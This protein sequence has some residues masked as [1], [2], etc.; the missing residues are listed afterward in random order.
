[1]GLGGSLPMAHDGFS[2]PNASAASFAAQARI[3]SQDLQIL[4]DGF[5]GNGVSSGCAVS[6]RAAGAN[7]SVDIAAG[8]I[9]REGSTVAV[10]SGN[11]AI[12]AAHATNPRI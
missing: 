11:V 3:F 12:S 4:A 1:A 5:H 7:M 8:N 2:V 10:G 9:V 6:Q